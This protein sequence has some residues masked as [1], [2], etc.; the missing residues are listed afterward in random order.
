[1]IQKPLPPKPPNADDEPLPLSLLPLPPFEVSPPLP[2]P[3]ENL[4][5][6][7]VAH[8]SA[9][10]QQSL[11]EVYLDKQKSSQRNW[12]DVVMEVG[13]QVAADLAFVV[14]LMT[15]VRKEQ[16]EKILKQVEL[17]QQQK[18][19]KEAAEAAAAARKRLNP[20]SGLLA[21]SPVR[22]SVSASANAHSATVSDTQANEERDPLSSSLNTEVMKVS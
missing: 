13:L 8:L 12:K 10:V 21:M 7:C 11:E 18:L 1:M 3:K 14:E 17:Q 6:H 9:L 2:P 20:M 5:A 19:Q 16:R 4:D 15:K 22:G